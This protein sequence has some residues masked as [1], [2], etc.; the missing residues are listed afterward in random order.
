MCE[1]SLGARLSWNVARPQSNVAACVLLVR[2]DVAAET[3]LALSGMRGEH[4]FLSILAKPYRK[5]NFFQHECS[6]EVRVS[7]TKRLDGL[8]HQVKRPGG[9]SSRPLRCCSEP[10]C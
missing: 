5:F 9:A 1:A 3:Q 7:E 8:V 10:S 4:L 6:R 2:V